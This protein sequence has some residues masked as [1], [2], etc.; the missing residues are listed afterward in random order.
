[1]TNPDPPGAE[2]DATLIE[3][4]VPP[5]SP[6]FGS[7]D[8]ERILRETESA[9]FPSAREEEEPPSA[10]P[11]SSSPSDAPVAHETEHGADEGATGEAAAASGI[12]ILAIIS[13]VLALALSPFALVFGYLAV[14]QARRARQK[15]ESAAW[16]AVSLG[17]VWAIAYVILGVVLGAAWLQVF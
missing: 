11:E 3:P 9:L 10:D 2:D 5:I 4:E 6:D 1:V 16:V 17:W 8:T 12:N 7:L 15:G 13:L 14:G